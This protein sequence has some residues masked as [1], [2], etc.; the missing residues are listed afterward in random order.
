[1]KAKAKAE[2][3]MPPGPYS[4]L[5]QRALRVASRMGLWLLV[6]GLADNPAWRVYSRTSGRLVLSYFPR[7]RRWLA[8]QEE[9]HCRGYREALGKAA[10]LSRP[11]QNDSRD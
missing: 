2:L 11:A 9:G 5:A 10:G 7:S 4:E 3:S 1:M 8:G 6:E